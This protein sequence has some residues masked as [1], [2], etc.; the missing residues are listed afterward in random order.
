MNAMLIFLTFKTLPLST[1]MLFL[2]LTMCPSWSSRTIIY[3][4]LFN[5]NELFFLSNDV[6]G[7]SD[8]DDHSSWDRIA[9]SCKRSHCLPGGFSH[10]AIRPIEIDQRRLTDESSWRIA[11]RDDRDDKVSPQIH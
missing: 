2:R 8:P 3:S 5:N 4:R 10:R 1:K 11:Y 6:T 7:E 9:E